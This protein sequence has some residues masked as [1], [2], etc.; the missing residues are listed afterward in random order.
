MGSP[1]NEIIAHRC[2]AG[3][4]AGSK[5]RRRREATRDCRLEL[6]VRPNSW[7]EQLE[8]MAVGIPKIDADP[9][10]RPGEAALA[11]NALLFE[12]LPPR[13]HARRGNAETEMRLAAR[14]VGWN[15]SERQDRSL[16]IAATKEE[17]QDLAMANIEG[18]EAFI[19]LHDRIA[20]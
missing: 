11:G 4:S 6:V 1:R 19:G 15:C 10:I 16:G 2:V 14:A 8:K 7:R 18:A 5:Q 13:R 9:S 3:N 12:P 20:K 17:Q